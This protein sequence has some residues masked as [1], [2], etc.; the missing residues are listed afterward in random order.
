MARNGDNLANDDQGKTEFSISLNVTEPVKNGSGEWEVTAL[1]RVLCR[2]NKA[3][4]PPKEV[5][6]RLTGD[7]KT[8]IVGTGYTDDD[9]GILTLPVKIEKPGSYLVFAILTDMP[10]ICSVKS[11][12]VADKKKKIPSARKIEIAGDYGDYRLLVTV[13]G[14][15]GIGFPN[16]PIVIT[17]QADGKVKSF[18][19]KKTDKTGKIELKVDFTENE[20]WITIF[21]PGANDKLQPWEKRLFGPISGGKQ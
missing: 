15:D 9:T 10:G 1:I 2:R 13:S 21:F 18:F 5:S 7:N 8:L 14:E 16:Q 20:R 3:P 12:S 6:V 11:I 19:R 4:K 17:Q